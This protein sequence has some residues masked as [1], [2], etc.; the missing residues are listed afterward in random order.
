MVGSG[1]FLGDAEFGQE[2]FEVVAAASAA[3]EAGV[4]H[5]VVGQYRCRDPVCFS[6]CGERLDNGV[7]GDS[8]VGGDR[9]GVARMVVEPDQ[10]LDIGVAGEPVVGEV[11][12][13]ALIG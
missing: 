12:L 5:G 7:A 13:P 4:D 9:E 1:V 8:G 10:D 6:C 3:G 11:R 2:G